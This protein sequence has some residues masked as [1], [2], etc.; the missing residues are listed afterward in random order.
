M[1]FRSVMLFLLG[2]CCCWC[3]YDEHLRGLVDEVGLL[4]SRC[5]CR[6]RVHASVVPMVEWEGGGEEVN[7]MEGGG[8]EMNGS[9][10]ITV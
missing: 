3:M 8:E 4:G 9:I 6:C 2:G 1:L 10:I 5:C 7:W